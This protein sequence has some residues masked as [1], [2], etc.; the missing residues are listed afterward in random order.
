MAYIIAMDGPAGAGKSTIARRIASKLN[1]LFINSGGFFRT[2]ALYY[3]QNNLTEDEL[4]KHLDNI[5]IEQKGS[6][7]FLNNT[8][9]TSHIT[10]PAISAVAS[11]IA[12]NESVRKKTEGLIKQMAVKN[13][14]VIEGR[15][16]TTVVFPNA[17]L[18]CWVFAS[19][20]IRAVRRQAQ[21]PSDLSYE[22]VL[23]GIKK[24]D[25]QDSTRKI[26]PLKRA[27]DAF[28]V[29]TSNITIGEAVDKIYNEFNKRIKQSS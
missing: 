14:V 7:F 18:K 27:D 13:N 12:R 20:E 8:N 19:P 5:A 29:D 24:R 23:E 1:F 16:T 4:E 25:I 9:V 10:G 2:I 11:V 17:T 22:E 28:D 26:S 21:I 3:L 6:D 15:D